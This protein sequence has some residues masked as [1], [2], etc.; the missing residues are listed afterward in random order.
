M[1]GWVREH[2]LSTTSPAPRSNGS[3]DI[4][5]LRIMGRS[6]SASPY[7]ETRAGSFAPGLKSG[8]RER[9]KIR[10]G[11]LVIAEPGP[12]AYSAPFRRNSVL[13]KTEFLPACDVAS[14][15][16]LLSFAVIVQ[17]PR[18]A[19]LARTDRA[20]PA[21]PVTGSSGFLNVSPRARQFRVPTAGTRGSAERDLVRGPSIWQ[22]DT[23]LF[24]RVPRRECPDPGFRKWRFQSTQPRPVRTSCCQLAER[25]V[26][27]DSTV[28]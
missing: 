8:Y 19:E 28:L 9:V 23:S 12:V 16:P 7:R 26:R 24:Q 15:S 4:V 20:I 17:A 11:S 2:D 10:V 21:S 13:R 14:N 18:A 25:E 5:V 22:L 27:A 1:A 6:A 3:G